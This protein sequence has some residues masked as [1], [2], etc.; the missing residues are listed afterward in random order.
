MTFEDQEQK[1]KEMNQHK[2]REERLMHEVHKRQTERKK[3]KRKRRK[4]RK[5]KH[6]KDKSVKKPPLVQQATLEIIDDSPQMG[7]ESPSPLARGISKDSKQSSKSKD[8]RN[9]QQFPESKAP[10]HASRDKRFNFPHPNIYQYQSPVTYQHTMN[11]FN[12]FNRQISNMS[13]PISTTTRYSDMMN[14]FQY[15]PLYEALSSQR[16]SSLQIHQLKEYTEQ[17]KRM[18]DLIRLREWENKQVSDYNNLIRQ[19]SI[20][21]QSGSF[22]SSFSYSPNRSISPRIPNMSIPT[23]LRDFGI[24]SPGYSPDI[25][26]NLTLFKQCLIILFI[27]FGMF[28]ILWLV[29]EIMTQVAFTPDMQYGDPKF[30]DP[31]YYDADSF[32]DP[33]P[34]PSPT[35]SVAPLWS[36]PLPTS[37]PVRIREQYEEIKSS[38]NKNLMNKFKEGLKNR[39]ELK[40]MQKSQR[41]NWYISWAIVV[42]I[43][44]LTWSYAYVGGFFKHPISMIGWLCSVILIYCVMREVMVDDGHIP[45]ERY[46]AP[47]NWDMH[48]KDNTPSNNIDILDMDYPDNVWDYYGNKIPAKLCEGYG[49]E[50]CANMVSTDRYAYSKSLDEFMDLGEDPSIRAGNRQTMLEL[51]T[52]GDLYEIKA[53]KEKELREREARRDKLHERRYKKPK[54]RPESAQRYRKKKERDKDKPAF[55]ESKSRPRSRPNMRQNKEVEVELVESLWMRRMT[56]LVLW[57]VFIALASLCF[58]DWSYRISFCAIFILGG[59]SIFAIFQFAENIL[60]DDMIELLPALTLYIIIPTLVAVVMGYHIFECCGISDLLWEL[61]VYEDQNVRK[62]IW[63]R[64][65]RFMGFIV[66]CVSLYYRPMLAVQCL[67]ILGFIGVALVQL[68]EHFSKFRMGWRKNRRQRQREASSKM[69]HKDHVIPAWT[70]QKMSHRRMG[71]DI[72]RTQ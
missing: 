41:I 11:Q 50:Q 30:A 34:I 70:K 28:W 33:I 6:I 23:E 3:K 20:R 54:V 57:V 18:N 8:T 40:E 56:D 72:C 37:Y 29:F 48:Y 62:W 9:Y 64:I 66:L 44:C 12:G 25:P 51:E 47:D 21:Q 32:T 7:N 5:D 27:M 16:L 71:Y 60:S 38:D 39:D 31:P 2:E 19:Q 46:D 58:N 68:Y 35:P 53:A 49:A 63:G 4:R 15:P 61:G 69:Y 10:K 43:A 55:E 67:I 26:V 59:I 36:E 52:N 22:N 45:R 1:K 24:I 13:T 14:Q 65:W 42:I 17:Q